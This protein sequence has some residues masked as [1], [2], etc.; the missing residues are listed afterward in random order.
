ML[1]K[2]GQKIGSAIIPLGEGKRPVLLDRL[3][4]RGLEA[5]GVKEPDEALVARVR[6]A[7]ADAVVERGELAQAYQE[8][9]AA[10]AEAERL[11]REIARL[12]KRLDQEGSVIFTA[13]DI[14]E[15]TVLLTYGLS[16]AEVAAYK[17]VPVATIREVMKGKARAR[18]PLPRPQGRPRSTPRA[19][20]L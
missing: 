3:I 5:L 9:D 12:Q 4:R 10:K 14:R 20:D 6:Q 1:E 17:D 13:Q 2:L 11:R 19:L 16:E 7:L 8:R 15:I 18:V